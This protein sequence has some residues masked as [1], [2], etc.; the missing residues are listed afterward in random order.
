MVA[1]TTRWDPTDLLE[2]DEAIGAYLCG[3]RS[4]DPDND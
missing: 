3:F 4:P 1:Q 2:S